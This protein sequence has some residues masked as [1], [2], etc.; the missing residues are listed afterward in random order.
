MM[1][2]L[3]LNLDIWTNYLSTMQTSPSNMY[4]VPASMANTSSV[5]PDQTAPSD[6][7]CS[8]LH[9]L[10]IPTCIY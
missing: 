4:Y 6:A 5:N 2:R 10:L 9:C 3:F 7:V 8:D 1:N